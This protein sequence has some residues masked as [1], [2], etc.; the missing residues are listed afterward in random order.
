MIILEGLMYYIF[1]INNIELG[2][3]VW[4]AEKIM[5]FLLE[6][7][8]W[9]FSSSAPHLKHLHKD[10]R[11]VVYLAGKGNRFFAADFTIASK[12]YEAKLDPNEQD[13]LA[14]FPIR[15]EI[16]NI[17]L[18]AERLPI[19][20]VIAQLDFINDKKNYGLYFRQSTK[21]ID[22]KDFSLIVGDK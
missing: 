10:D 12:P 19:G 11:V 5:E 13:W 8:K 3:S 9:A 15:I 22:E 4:M 18:W 14:I 16:K 20:D 6:N 2:E 21:S 1:I 7:N 17:K